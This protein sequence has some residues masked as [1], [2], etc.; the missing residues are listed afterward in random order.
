MIN[1]KNFFTLEYAKKFLNKKGLELFKKSNQTKSDNS[2]KSFYYTALCSLFIIFVFFLSPKIIILKDN[3][4]VSSIEVKNNSKINLEKVLS[5]KK[6]K[7]QK[8]F[9]PMKNKIIGVT[10]TDSVFLDK[11]NKRLNA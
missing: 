8:L 9:V 6:L 7:G 11:E 10:I 5:G 2:F 4:V 1:K 3:L